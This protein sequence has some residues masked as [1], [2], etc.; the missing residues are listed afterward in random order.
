MI[1]NLEQ[2]WSQA[3]DTPR[4]FAISDGRPGNARQAEALA[5]ALLPGWVEALHLV[6]GAP[7]RWASPRGLPGCGRA[8]GAKFVQLL[9]QPP[10][11]VVGCGRQAALATRLLRDAGSQVVQILDPRISHR[12]WDV[13][14]IPEHDGVGGQNIIP[15]QGSLNPVNDAWLAA[16][17]IEFALLE[18]L[19]GPRLTVLIGGDSRHGKLADET[20]KTILEMLP[21]W[22]QDT[23][24]SVLVT[25]SRRTPFGLTAAVVEQM[26]TLPGLCWT[27]PDDG[28]NPYPGLLAFADRIVCTADSVNLLS[29]AC[30][31]LAPVCVL[32]IE[33]ASGGP[34]RFV[35][36]LLASGRVQTALTSPLKAS[37]AKTPLRETARVAAIVRERLFGDGELS[38]RHPRHRRLIRT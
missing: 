2:T 1:A 3:P 18:P 38:D 33:T 6:P 10:R 9:Q 32:G 30:A 5:S 36:S 35:R 26:R 16:A 19:P 34:G 20:E 29:E 25:T 24:G 37:P 23:G 12:Y 14:I 17:R 22:H 8:F 31:T 15:V 21:R 28:V 13:L 11:W 27:G 7:W 4:I